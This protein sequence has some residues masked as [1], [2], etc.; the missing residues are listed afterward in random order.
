MIALEVL[1]RL[2][3]VGVRVSRD[4]PYIRVRPREA[5]TPELREMVQGARGEVLAE[6]AKRAEIDGL[7][8]TLRDGAPEMWSEADVEE[9]AANAYRDAD[10]ALNSLRALVGGPVSGGQS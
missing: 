10:A 1:D 6:L 8:A 4:G 9:A 7:L 3:A 2:S 5:V